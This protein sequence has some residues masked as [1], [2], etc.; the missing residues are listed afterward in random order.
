[1]SAAV[2]ISRMGLHE[3]YT[4]LYPVSPFH[5]NP[6]YHRWLR[7]MTPFCILPRDSADDPKASRRSLCLHRVQVP[8]PKK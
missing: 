4:G 2:G 5:I 7:G 1:M 3:T 8:E 6:R